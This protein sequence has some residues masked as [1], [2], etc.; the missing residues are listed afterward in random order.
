MSVCCGC[1]CFQ[2][3]ISARGRSFV[4]SS[5]TECVCLLECNQLQQSPSTSVPVGRRG[6]INPLNAELNPIWN[7]LTLLGA[8]PILHVSR[9]RVKNEILPVPAW[10]QTVQLVAR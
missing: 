5:L 4:Q 3:E 6:Q 8:H 10:N 7:L 9:I 2:V 1:M